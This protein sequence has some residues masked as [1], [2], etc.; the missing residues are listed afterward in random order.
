MPGRSR[1]TRRF[2]ESVTTP[3]FFFA[4]TLALSS[5]TA[6]LRASSHFGSVS[7]A[8]TLSIGAL[9]FC[10]IGCLLVGSGRGRGK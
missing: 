4:L 1:R 7:S 2:I 6:R 3:P 10:S 8:N 5:P 9:Y